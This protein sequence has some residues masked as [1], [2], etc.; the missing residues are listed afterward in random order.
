MQ[1]EEFQ[2]SLASWIACKDKQGHGL[3]TVLFWQ[4]ACGQYTRLIGVQISY[5]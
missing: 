4:I 2:Q 5:W 1:T 3:L